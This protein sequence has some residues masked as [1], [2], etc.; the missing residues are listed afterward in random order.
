MAGATVANTT[1]KV[2]NHCTE[3]AEFDGERT[4]QLSCGAKQEQQ[5]RIGQVN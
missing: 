3:R 1:Q 2:N 4:N 5:E